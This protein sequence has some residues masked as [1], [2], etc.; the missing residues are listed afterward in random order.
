MMWTQF[1]LLKVKKN[2]EINSTYTS[3][4]PAMHA[5]RDEVHTL[6]TFRRY[7]MSVV[8]SYNYKKTKCF[9][10]ANFMKNL[11]HPIN[12]SCYFFNKQF[13]ENRAEVLGNKG[14]TLFTSPYGKWLSQD[15]FR[16]HSHILKGVRWKHNKKVES[17]NMDGGCINKVTHI[18]KIWPSLS[19]F[20]R[21]W[22]CS[23]NLLKNSYTKFNRVDHRREGRA[24]GCDTKFRPWYLYFA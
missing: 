3:K 18:S 17:S 24:G 14:Q 11:H 5:T 15:P 23:T 6:F 7:V 8:F 1:E 12:V 21:K 4:S 20:Q 19:R 2:R 13:E 22:W 10:T 9:P 16:L